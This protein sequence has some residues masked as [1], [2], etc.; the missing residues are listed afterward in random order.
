M[1]DDTTRA[2]FCLVEGDSAGTF[3]VNVSVFVYSQIFCL[4]KLVKEKGKNGVFRNF[5]ACEL[6]LWKV[7][8]FQCLAFILSST[9]CVGHSL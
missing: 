3:R 1:T 8:H 6:V 2:L 4:K 5:D 7:S 9:A